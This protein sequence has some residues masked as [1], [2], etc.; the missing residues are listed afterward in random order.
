MFSW[1]RL[2]KAVMAAPPSQQRSVEGRIRSPSASFR[3]AASRRGRTASN[4]APLWSQAT[5]RGFCSAERPRLAPL[6]PLRRAG[7]ARPPLRPLNDLRIK[8]SSASTIPQRRFGLSCLSAARNRCRHRKVVLG[9]IWDR[10]ADLAIR[11][12]PGLI[13]PAFLVVQPGDRSSREGIES[14]AKRR[15]ALQRPA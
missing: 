9:S 3:L 2:A 10:S 8:V 4:V 11:L 6:P 13:E 1:A 5:T 14:L 7:L 15:R 12:A